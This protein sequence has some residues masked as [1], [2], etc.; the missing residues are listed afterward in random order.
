MF[1]VLM[2][3]ERWGENTGIGSL[4]PMKITKYLLKMGCS[5]TVVC[6]SYAASAKNPGRELEEV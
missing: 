5:V 6:G 1:H 2:I 4:R 3:A